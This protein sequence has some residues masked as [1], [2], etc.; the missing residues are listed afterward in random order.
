MGGRGGGAVFVSR[1]LTVRD[2]AKKSLRGVSVA[3]ARW[4]RGTRRFPTKCPA[5]NDGIVIEET[6]KNWFWG[7]AKSLGAERNFVLT[8]R[9]IIGGARLYSGELFGARDVRAEYRGEIFG[10]AY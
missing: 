9:K 8:A 1:F 10:F 6:R 4:P 3:G 7:H 2:A 5:A